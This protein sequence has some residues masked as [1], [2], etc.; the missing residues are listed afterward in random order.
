MIVGTS[1]TNMGFFKKVCDIW[2]YKNMPLLNGLQLSLSQFSECA[3][4]YNLR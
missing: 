1:V 3:D 2:K 4:F